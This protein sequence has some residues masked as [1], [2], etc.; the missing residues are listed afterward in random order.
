MAL[1]WLKLPKLGR[2]T[3]AP[4]RETEAYPNLTLIGQPQNA[5]KKFV[6]KPTP[7]NLRYFAKT[8]FAR[9]AMSAIKNPIVLTQWEVRPKR[10]IALNSELKRQI[11]LVTRCL[12]QPN[13]DDSFRTFLEQIIEDILCGAGAFEQQIGGD[14]DRPLW[15]W[16]VDGLAIQVYPGWAG[17]QNE[18][19]YRQVL[20]YGGLGTAGGTTGVDLRNEELVYLRPN[21]T[22]GSPFGIGPLEVAFLSISRKLAV[23]E[24]AGN[25]SGNASPSRI[26]HLGENVDPDSVRAFRSYWEN[27]MEGQGKLPIAG[28][29]KA[30]QVLDLKPDGDSALYISYQ[31][32]LIREIAVA[33]NLDASV[34]SLTADVNR[35]TSESAEDR[36]ADHAIRPTATLIASHITRETINT[37][38]GF[39][40]LEFAFV[41]LD[42]KDEKAAADIFSSYYNINVF[43]PNEIRA[44]LGEEPATHAWGDLTYA[45]MT[46]AQMA[47]RGAKV[48]DDTDLPQLKTAPDDATTPGIVSPSDKAINIA[49]QA[50]PKPQPATPGHSK[51]N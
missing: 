4:H 10:G 9:R 23:E 6:Y 15:M 19:R 14:K 36:N 31:T 29:S 5:S 11:E 12:E 22:T 3:N 45:D 21:P 2:K 49:K 24:F 17:N 25:V 42:R 28:G 38:L 50:T 35:D 32:L 40:Q 1:N 27:E 39:S 43:T 48:I 47:A 26:L 30:P 13:E 18:A 16:P 34:M 8:P 33:F 46:I 41:G 7:R 37:R 20:G 44:Q 51:G